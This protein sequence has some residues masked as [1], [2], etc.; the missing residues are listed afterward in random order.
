MKKIYETYKNKQKLFSI[1]VVIYTEIVTE[2][3]SSYFLYL[4]DKT[5]PSFGDPGRFAVLTPVCMVISVLLLI[6]CVCLIFIPLIWLTV[7]S[8][9][10]NIRKSKILLLWGFVVL[11][12][13]LGVIL[14]VF[15]FTIPC[16]A[17]ETLAN[18]LNDQFD[19]FRLT[20]P[21]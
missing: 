6:A 18:F 5:M 20:S 15:G 17:A 12:G 9:Q 11:A 16:R 8:K 2:F 10:D 3:C 1:V 13:V 14:A 19:F 21:Y 4:F 7:K